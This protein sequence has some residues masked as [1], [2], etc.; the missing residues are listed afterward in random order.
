MSAY[1]S[2]GTLHIRPIMHRRPIAGLHEPARLLAALLIVGRIG[3]VTRGAILTAS[4]A[5]DYLSSIRRRPVTVTHV[6]PWQGKADV[7]VLRGQPIVPSR[8]AA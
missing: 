6:E 2:F 4:A 1:P 7:T 8:K 3:Q 5:N